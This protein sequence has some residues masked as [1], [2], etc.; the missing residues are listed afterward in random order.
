MKTYHLD[1]NFYFQVDEN[2]IVL[3]RDVRLEDNS[4]NNFHDYHVVKI[5]NNEHETIQVITPNKS[6]CSF[7]V[8]TNK[9]QGDQIN[10][11]DEDDEF[12]WHKDE[13][14]IIFATDS[15]LYLLT[16]EKMDTGNVEDKVHECEECSYKSTRRSNLLRHMKT[17]HAL[18]RHECSVCGTNFADQCSLKRHMKTAHENIIYKCDHCDFKATRASNIKE[19]TNV[20]H[21]NVRFECAECDFKGTSRR[22]LRRHHKAKHSDKFGDTE[23]A[24]DVLKDPGQCPSDSCNFSTVSHTA[25]LK[26]IEFA[27]NPTQE[28]LNKCAHEGCDY[29]GNTEASM[30]YHIKT[31]HE[32]TSFKC[33]KCDQVFKSVTNL[34]QHHRSIHDQS[35]WVKCE[36][37]DHVSK[38]KAELKIHLHAEHLGVTYKCEKCNYRAK[39]KSKLTDHYKKVH[40]GVRFTCPEDGC[41]F[42]ATTKFN[43]KRHQESVHEGLSFQCPNCDYKS[44]QKTHLAAHIQSRHNNE[45]FK[46]DHDGCNY[47][48]FTPHGLSQHKKAEH[49]GIRYGCPLCSYKATQKSNLKNHIKKIHN[50]DEV[51]LQDYKIVADPLS[52]VSQKSNV[53]RGYKIVAGFDLIHND[54]VVS[55]L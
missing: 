26:H 16:S 13:S 33:D 51:L 15:E 50:N 44:S 47:E 35:T 31:V 9:D 42:A 3:D 32:G 2:N 20:V 28:D 52:C 12:E 54:D 29:V 34:N 55:D 36:L 23:N 1:D 4:L 5:D 38:T 37:C 27:H 48:C 45:K 49:E 30:K 19:H 40:L 10:D 18:T 25:L 21:F 53:K 46:C 14:K 39:R 17:A 7:T 43:L 24:L 22:A 8:Q 6:T 11:I 41:D